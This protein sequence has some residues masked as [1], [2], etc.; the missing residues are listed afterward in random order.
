MYFELLKITH[1]VEF[2]RKL[3]L[4]PQTQTLFCHFQ[5]FITRQ[6][7]VLETPKRLKIKSVIFNLAWG[8][9]TVG[10]YNK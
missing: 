5:K 8:Q 1:H 6:L 9:F 2:S 3:G 7:D 4:T 10:Q